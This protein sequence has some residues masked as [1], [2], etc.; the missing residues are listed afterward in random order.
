MTHMETE[1]LEPTEGQPWTALTRLQR[2]VPVNPAFN[3]EGQIKQALS[4]SSAGYT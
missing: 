1:V 3:K 2:I 4:K